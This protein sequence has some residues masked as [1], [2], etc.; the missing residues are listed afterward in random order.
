VIVPI[1][2]QRFHLPREAVSTALLSFGVAGIAG[3][4]L[5]KRLASRWSA[6]RLITGAVGALIAVFAAMSLLPTA[7]SVPLALLVAWAVANDVFMPSQQRRLAELAP[8]ARGLVLALNA[9]ALY[10]GMAGGSLLA[11]AVS[12]RGG[13]ALP[14]LVSAGLAGA[15][16]LTLWLSRRAATAAKRPP[17]C[18]H[19]ART[20]N[21]SP[22]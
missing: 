13:F 1:L 21:G 16:L 6:D 8:E 9:S 12:V 4:A 20:P 22:P 19:T 11:G 2:Q 3:N 18:S 15:S 7:P 10:L 14:P 5:A 17:G